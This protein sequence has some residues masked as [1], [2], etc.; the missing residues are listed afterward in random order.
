M[1]TQSA[2]PGLAR[3]RCSANAP[4]SRVFQAIA[5]GEGEPRTWV[6]E[7][8]GLGSN[9]G[10]TT[11]KSI[12]LWGNVHA[13]QART[14]RPTHCLMNS[15][16]RTRTR[17]HTCDQSKSRALQVPVSLSLCWL[18]FPL[19]TMPPSFLSSTSP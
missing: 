10:S 17:M 11:L 16:T 18:C 13:L 9:L 2:G 1:S 6:L 19:P 14:L 3:V 15:R 8:N 7:A 5:W 4:R 12:A